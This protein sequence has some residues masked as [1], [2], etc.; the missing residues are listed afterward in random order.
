MVNQVALTGNPETPD[1]PVVM[2]PNLALSSETRKPCQAGREASSGR[3]RTPAMS[4]TIREAVE[5]C[6]ACEA[7]GEQRDIVVHA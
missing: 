7:D 1:C 4:A 3:P 2:T 5:R 6:L